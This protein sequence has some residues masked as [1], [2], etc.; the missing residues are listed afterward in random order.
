MKR[1]PVPLVLMTG[2]MLAI[3]GVL[4]LQIKMKGFWQVLHMI[5]KAICAKK[6]TDLAPFLRY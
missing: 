5:A 4:C 2:R 3:L 1:C 6:F